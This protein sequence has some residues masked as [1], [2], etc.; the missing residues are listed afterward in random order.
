M[1]LM[2]SAALHTTLIL[3][4]IALAV[5]TFA[6]LFLVVAPYGRHT[7]PGWGPQISARVGWMVMETPALAGFLFFYLGGRHRFEVAPLAL[8]SLWL[9][10]YGHRVLVFPLRMRPGAKK[11]PVAIA[12]MAVLFNIL[13]ASVNAPQVSEFGHYDP[14]WLR[15]P[16]FVGGA[17]LFL[18]GFVL[19]LRADDVLRNLRRPGET[20]YRIPTGALHDLVAN[21]NYLGEIL[22]WT[23]WAIATWSLAGF[24]FTLYTAANLV[25]RA[26]S[27]RSW[28]RQTFPDYPADRRAIFPWIL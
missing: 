17:I 1:P 2:P 26:I 28:Y 7:R 16:R 9:L 23:G 14:E 5:I 18:T 11:M 8:A 21:P 22:E 3:V 13:N 27:N 6:S 25:P 20:A 24:S 12:A 15:D 19:N 10:H 4:E